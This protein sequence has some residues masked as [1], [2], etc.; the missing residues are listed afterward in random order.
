MRNTLQRYLDDNV[1]AS[2]LQ[3]GGEYVH[4]APADN[5]AVHDV[6]A[7]L[8]EKLCGAGAGSAH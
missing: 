2:L 3:A 4:S 6:Q 7:E 8:M 1:G 5:E